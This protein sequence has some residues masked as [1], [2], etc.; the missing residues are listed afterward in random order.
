MSY[1]MYTVDSKQNIGA[2]IVGEYK[3]FIV[4]PSSFSCL[5]V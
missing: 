4:Y 5:A 1:A 3:L 2:V